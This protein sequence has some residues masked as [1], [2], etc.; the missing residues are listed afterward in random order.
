MYGLTDSSWT[1]RVRLIHGH[2]LRFKDEPHV[3]R[4]QPLAAEAEDFEPRDAPAQLAN[5]L[6]GVQIARGL[7]AGNHH[8]HGA[9]GSRPGRRRGTAG[10]GSQIDI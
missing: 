6:A 7:A 8:A 3:L 9:T 4:L 2:W 10:A 5:E 1:H